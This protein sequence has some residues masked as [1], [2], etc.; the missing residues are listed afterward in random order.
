MGPAIRV[1]NRCRGVD[2]GPDRA[3]LVG[4]DLDTGPLA[5]DDG[6]ADLLQQFAGFAGEDFVGADVVRLPVD[7]DLAA[8]QGDP[9]VRIGE[10]LGEQPPVGAAVRRHVQCPLGD[11][12]PVAFHHDALQL[13]DELDVSQRVGVVAGAL[14]VEVVEVQ[15]LLEDRGVE[16]RGADADHHGVVVH[17]VISANLTGGVR[18]ALRVGGG[19]P[20]QQGRG[21]DRAAGHDDDPRLHVDLGAVADDLD[22]GGVATCG[23][24]QHPLD[25]AVG[26]QLDGAGRDGRPHAGDVGVRLRRDQAGKPV[27]GLAPDAA[28]A[29]AQVDTQRDV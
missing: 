17:H 15:C 27:A 13:A 18:Q 7:D 5:E 6:V 28:A 3:G 14:G 10:V 9:V 21:V 11:F 25:V 20:Q 19:G 2:A 1:E 22:T 23:I 24:G 29:I 16:L 12:G 26:E 4:V 8:V